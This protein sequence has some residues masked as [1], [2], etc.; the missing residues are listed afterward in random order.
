MPNAGPSGRVGRLG[1]R[2]QRSRR[3][4]AY[5][6]ASPAGRC[7]DRVDPG[8]Q[9]ANA[10]GAIPS[11]R[12]IGARIIGAR[13]N[14]A[15][16]GAHACT[17]SC[18]IHD[19]TTGD[20]TDDRHRPRHRRARSIG[21][22]C[23]RL[24]TS[25]PRPAVAD[26]DQQGRSLSD[27][28]PHAGHLRH[29]DRDRQGAHVSHRARHEG[30]DQHARYRCRARHRR[31]RGD[32]DRG[33]EA[34]RADGRAEAEARHAEV[35]ALHRRGGR[36]RRVGTRLAPARC[37]RVRSRDALEASQEAGLRGSASTRRSSSASIRHSITR[38]DR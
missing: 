20:R 33:P 8:G 24:H 5:S 22:R 38:D 2:V 3:R 18:S 15:A 31:R 26:Q 28:G 9:D 32:Q 29:R 19:A 4:A 11:A 10:T 23:P 14:A 1:A 17:D 35:A 37:R 7:S 6:L 16:R 30:R 25:S 12:T 36:S 13:V 27:G 34:P 21:S